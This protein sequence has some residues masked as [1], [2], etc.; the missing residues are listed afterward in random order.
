V[1]NVD[2]WYKAF[3]VTPDNKYYLKP[4]ARTRIW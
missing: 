3:N 2:A 4:E 1:R